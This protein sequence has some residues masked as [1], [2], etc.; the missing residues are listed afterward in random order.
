M[1][2]AAQ[3]ILLRFFEGPVTSRNYLLYVLRALL[4]LAALLGS[5]A[6]SLSTQDPASPLVLGLD[7]IPVA[8][9]DLESAAEG[10]RS[11]GFVLKPGRHHE[12]GIRNQHV[13]FPDGTEIELIT[14]S[15]ARD[16]LTAE[17][18]RHLASGDGAAFLG[19]YAPNLDQ[20]AHRFDAEGRTYRYDGGLL[21]FPASDELRYIFFGERLRS[22]TD[23]P[24]HFEHS[25]GAEA[26][27]RVWIAG[28]DLS[29]ERQ[30]LTDLGATIAER[31]VFVPD[32]ALAQVAALPQAEVVFL[33]ASRQLLPG[34][35]IVGAT[36]RTSNLDA[37]SRA[38]NA[39]NLS[40]PPVV[41]TEKGRSIFVPPA[42]AHGLWIEFHQDSYENVRPDG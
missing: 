16:A 35:R 12:N 8:V 33:P 13:K 3:C 17:Y 32:R 25:N 21:T 10:Y 22:A 24:Q 36:I 1:K 11:L 18:L 29:S 40:V 38:L 30:L 4:L 6:C 34:R 19:F 28:D 31:V 20:L 5:S 7:H 14:A 15:R 41:H 27:I 23:Q 26:L 9:T 37:L 2:A 39:A 42:F